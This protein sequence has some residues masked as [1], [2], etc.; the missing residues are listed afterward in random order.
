MAKIKICLDA[1]HYGKYNQS[2]VN[3]KYYESDMTWKLHN[4][5][6]S[7]LENYGIEVV[8][9]RKSQNVDLA[10][11]KRGKASK[12]CDLFLSIHS[13]AS[14]SDEADAADAYCQV[15]DNT[16]KIDEKSV[17]IGKKLASVVNKTMACKGPAQVHRRVGNYNKD[18][19]GV[20]RGARDV[21]T[22]GVLMEHSF[23]TNLRATNWLLKDTNLKKLAKAEAK[24]IADYFG[25]KKSTSKPTNTSSSTATA[26]TSNFKPY[27]VKVVCKSLNIRKTPNWSNSDV[28][29]TVK[30]NEAYTIVAEK[31]LDGTKFGKLKSGAGWISLGNK[32]VK[33]VE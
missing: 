27:I 28:V 26:T 25:V 8:T 6:K 10:L 3:K 13:N 11:E 4:F 31:N 14:S 23:H 18:Y 33:R 15:S 16:T 24:V 19:Y 9:T 30:K 5:L 2:P 32:Y 21:G 29:G 12:G 22:A 20:L 1:G 17:E 7:E